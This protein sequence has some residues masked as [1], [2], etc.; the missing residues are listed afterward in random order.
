MNCSG[1]YNEI[2]PCGGARHISDYSSISVKG[3]RCASLPSRVRA[4]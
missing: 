2:D 3:C 1:I 4:V